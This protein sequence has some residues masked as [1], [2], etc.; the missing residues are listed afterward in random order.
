MSAFTEAKKDAAKIV[1]L[2]RRKEAAAKRHAEELRR[3]EQEIVCVSSRYGEI[4]GGNALLN[5]AIDH[6]RETTAYKT[7]GA[8]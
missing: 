5:A 2:E 1:K 3:I 7:E 8:A 6:V 4:E